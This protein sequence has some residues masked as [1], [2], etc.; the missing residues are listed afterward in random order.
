[1]VAALAVTLMVPGQAE[2]GFAESARQKART[3]SSWYSK[4]NPGAKD[5][6]KS[7][8]S[9]IIVLGCCRLVA[10]RVLDHMNPINRDGTCADFCE[11]LYFRS[12][13]RDKANKLVCGIWTACTLKYVHTFYSEMKARPV[14]KKPASAQSAK[15]MKKYN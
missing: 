15:S 4:F 9:M 2:A 8:A 14:K 6:A 3:V 5:V 1:M 7:Y 11:S 10:A 13:L 12:D